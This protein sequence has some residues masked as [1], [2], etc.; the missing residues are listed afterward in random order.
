[1]MTWRIYSF[2]YEDEE[3]VLR[4]LLSV[5]PY[6]SMLINIWPGNW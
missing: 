4:E 2:F 1:M 5:Y 3:G 6:L